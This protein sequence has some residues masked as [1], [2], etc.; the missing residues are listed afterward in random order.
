MRE[1]VVLS[2]GQPTH[3]GEFQYPDYSRNSVLNV[4]LF[5]GAIYGSI[6][7]RSRRTDAGMPLY[8]VNSIAWSVY[9]EVYE[10][11]RYDNGLIISLA[12]LLLYYL[13]AN[14]IFIKDTA[15]FIGDMLS[16][17]NKKED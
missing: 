6:L 8:I 3:Y 10:N 16:L 14:G 2:S 15:A 5:K 12:H 1:P 13:N 4:E 17:V 7:N 11:G 9:K